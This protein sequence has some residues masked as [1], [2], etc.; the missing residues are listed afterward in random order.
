MGPVEQSI[1]IVAGVG[2]LSLIFLSDSNLRWA[3]LIGLLP[4]LTGVVGWCPMYAWL[5]QD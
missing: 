3:G 4:L 5:T 2:L 1:R